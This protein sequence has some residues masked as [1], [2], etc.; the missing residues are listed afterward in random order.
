MPTKPSAAQSADL[1]EVIAERAYFKALS[2]GFE[3][4]FELDDWLEAER[5]VAA[6]ATRAPK[7]RA[8]RGA[9]ARKKS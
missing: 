8:K 4:G 3:P 7:P 6:L 9:T 5:E 2:R 1:T